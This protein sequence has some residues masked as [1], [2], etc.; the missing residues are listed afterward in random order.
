[1]GATIEIPTLDAPAK[2]KV[3]SGTT[4][5]TTLK[6]TGKGVETR[7]GTGDLLVTLTIAVNPEIGQDERRLLEELRSAEAGWNPRSHM[8]VSR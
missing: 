6:L 3:P 7:T 5:G 8:G 2:I 1:L 4:P